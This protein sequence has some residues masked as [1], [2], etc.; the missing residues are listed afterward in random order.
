MY[1]G[2]GAKVRNGNRQGEIQTQDR[3]KLITGGYVTT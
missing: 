1:R 2:L 3:S